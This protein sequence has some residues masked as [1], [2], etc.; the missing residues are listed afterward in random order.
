M[1][2]RV[3]VTGS[4]A[5]TDI[6]TLATWLNELR[7]AHPDM[8]V[9]HG[10]CTSGGDAI[11]DHWAWRFDVPVE[12]HPADW[13]RHGSRAGFVRNAEMVRLGADVCGAFVVND[14][15]GALMCAGLAADAGIPVTPVF[16]TVPGDPPPGWHR[17]PRPYR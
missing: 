5:W 10:D 15:R 14:S 9:V 13:K 16:R 6:P 8:V 7:S 1:P 17:P 2:Y 4:R 12:R 3:L 11:A